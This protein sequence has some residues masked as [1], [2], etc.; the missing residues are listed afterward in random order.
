MCFSC[1]GVEGEG[2][3]EATGTNGVMDV[4]TNAVNNVEFTGPTYFEPLIRL[5]INR[6]KNN[7]RK[8]DYTMLMIITD[9]EIDDYIA[10]QNALKE[11]AKLPISI[12]IVGVGNAGSLY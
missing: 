7:K 6:T 5:V 3:E 9:G 8:E 2:N 10:T 12:V 11:A 4:Y 1:T